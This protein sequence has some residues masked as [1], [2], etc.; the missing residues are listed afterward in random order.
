MR[1]AGRGGLVL[2]VGVVVLVLVLVHINVRARA[3]ARA[4]A[5]ALVEGLK[6]RGGRSAATTTARV[7]VGGLAHARCPQTRLRAAPD[8]ARSARDTSAACASSRG[9]R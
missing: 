5:A 9:R 6:T 3:L 4:L 8:T 2:P 7:P 1:G